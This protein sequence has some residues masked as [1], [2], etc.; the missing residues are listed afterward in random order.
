M[1]VAS[2][3]LT[4]GRIALVTTADYVVCFL[5]G[6][7]YRT[8]K[9]SFSLDVYVKYTVAN[10]L[11]TLATCFAVR[12]AFRRSCFQLDSGRWPWHWARELR[13]LLLLWLGFDLW[14]YWVH[15]LAHKDKRVFRLCHGFHHE[16]REAEPLD[17][18]VASPFDTVV[19]GS[20]PLF[21]GMQLA[22]VHEKTFWLL[23]VS[24]LPLVML[25]HSRL[26]GAHLVHH[27]LL[28]YNFGATPLFDF[29]FG[30]RHI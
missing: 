4:P 28:K 6:L 2:S 1:S 8:S 14:F 19:L 27:R 7:K 5:A 3:S 11:Q 16:A 12:T 18:L 21:A 29:I 17:G 15:R 10:W 9:A 30:T 25:T 13:K 24:G 23:L 20:L 22:R 26:N